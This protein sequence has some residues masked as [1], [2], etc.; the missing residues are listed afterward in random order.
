MLIHRY[1]DLLFEQNLWIAVNT[2]SFLFRNCQWSF[3]L[4]NAWARRVR[5][6]GPKGSIHDEARKVLTSNLKGRLVFEAD[7]QSALIYLQI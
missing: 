6:V 7:D 3:D 1:P 4:L 5:C 2:G